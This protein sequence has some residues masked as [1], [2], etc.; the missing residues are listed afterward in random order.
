MPFLTKAD[1]I[2]DGP[3]TPDNKIAEIRAKKRQRE[4][5]D[6]YTSLLYL[7]YSSV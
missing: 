2:Y 4:K 5:V 1:L 3:L 7:T 6:G